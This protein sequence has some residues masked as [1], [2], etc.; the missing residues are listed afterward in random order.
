MTGLNG[1]PHERRAVLLAAVILLQAVTAAFFV[2][3]VVADL[4]IDGALDDVHM[5]LEAVA[6]VALVG[7][8][9]FLMIEL[10]RVLARMATLETVSQAAR[11]DMAEVIDAFFTDWHLTPSERDVALMVLKG[12]DNDDIAR[13]RGTAPGTVRAQCTAIYTKAGVESRA[14]LFSVFMEELLSGE[15][16]PPHPAG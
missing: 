12:I 2:A 1:T 4:A 6:A 14:Q 5:W 7:G 8:I 3:D 16:E 13:I 15:H 10:R 9:V 11:G